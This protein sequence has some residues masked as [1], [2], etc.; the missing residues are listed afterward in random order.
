MLS[1]IVAEAQMSQ[2]VMSLFHFQIEM[3]FEKLDRVV[4]KVLNFPSSLCPSC[5]LGL[6]SNHLMITQPE[7]H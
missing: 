1:T 3:N 5:C 4:V 7:R 2:L 6:P